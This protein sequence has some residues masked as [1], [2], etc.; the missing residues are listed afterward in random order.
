MHVSPSSEL[1]RVELDIPHFPVGALVTHRERR[2]F[3]T[4]RFTT[5]LSY[6]CFLWLPWTETIKQIESLSCKLAIVNWAPCPAGLLISDPVAIKPRLAKKKKCEAEGLRTFAFGA[7][8][9]S[10][11]YEGKG[12]LI[13][14]WREH[15]PSPGPAG[16]LE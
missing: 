5:W 15:V 14:S 10:P 1:L 11:A 16:I 6:G 7:C 8:C 12:E 9:C 4:R 13:L 3:F 2:S